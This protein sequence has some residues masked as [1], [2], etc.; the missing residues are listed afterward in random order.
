MATGCATTFIPTNT[1]P[2]FL[3]NYVP[4]SPTSAPNISNHIDLKNDIKIRPFSNLENDFSATWTKDDRILFA[5]REI[6]LDLLSSETRY[7]FHF[8]VYDIPSSSKAE[9]K[10]ETFTNMIESGAQWKGK[11][12]THY[13]TT[14]DYCKT[15][16]FDQ[17]MKISDSSGQKSF[18]IKKITKI[19]RKKKD[20]NCLE[21]YKRIK[22]KFGEKGARK[23]ISCP[24]FGATLSSDG[25]IYYNG[26]GGIYNIKDLTTY[27]DHIATQPN[28][29]LFTTLLEPYLVGIAPSPE[30]TRI[31]L[32]YLFE[33]KLLI[34][35]L[36]LN[37][38]PC[39]DLF[40]D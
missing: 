17:F 15:V 32:I 9:G 36:P 31:A 38:N 10:F 24:T 16:E 12:L 6:V 5:K 4:T 19:K 8:F 1:D 33:G 40:C 35:I 28:S 13:G 18:K 37:L 21:E 30:F 34:D 3:P 20:G 39:T 23:T 22:C 7:K 2:R 11:D 29:G 26:R 27:T 25:N 14:K